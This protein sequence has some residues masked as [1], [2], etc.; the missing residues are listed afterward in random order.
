MPPLRFWI[1]LI[2][3]ISLVQSTWYSSEHRICDPTGTS[4]IPYTGFKIHRQYVLKD[5]KPPMLHFVSLSHCGQGNLDY[6]RLTRTG[7]ETDIEWDKPICILSPDKINELYKSNVDSAKIPSDETNTKTSKL[8]RL[9][10][11]PKRP[12]RISLS[13][14][15]SKIS[16]RS[17]FKHN[18][19]EFLRK[20]SSKLWFIE[21][22]DD[23]LVTNLEDLSPLTYKGLRMK[24]LDGLKCYKLARRKKYALRQM[25]LY[26][27]Y[28]WV[29]GIF[30]CEVSQQAKEHYLK[31][32]QDSRDFIKPFQFK[33]DA[34][35]SRPLFPLI[36][37]DITQQWIEKEKGLT[38]SQ[39]IPYLYTPGSLDLRYG[40]PAQT[41]GLK[42]NTSLFD[43]H[44]INK[45]STDALPYDKWTLELEVNE[46]YNFTESD[47]GI[48][49]DA[50]TT[51]TNLLNQ[52]LKVDNKYLPWEWDKVELLGYE[53]D[54][55]TYFEHKFLGIIGKVKDKALGTSI[56]NTIQGHW[57]NLTL[58]KE[59]F[60]YLES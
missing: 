17:V 29:G 30:E 5:F 50:V 36:A 16:K 43:D 41:L 10:D 24:D 59:Q 48:I 12:H 33:C 60:S 6:E 14:I 35:N 56:L 1:I 46:S 51:S 19:N 13:H 23:S 26:A 39:R 20:I 4:W 44:V 55:L 58:S 49:T 32:L 22:T 8:L 27:P 28:T 7:R 25:M 31:S 21:Y 40:R 37:D 47:I 57:D 34:N 38:L 9:E 52:F 42:S 15:K 54:G 2:S 11:V 18:F 3:F 53:K 45:K